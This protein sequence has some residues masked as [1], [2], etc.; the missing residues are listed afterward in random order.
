MDR[1]LIETPHTDDECLGLLDQII[2]AGYLHHFDW[3]C[4][5]GDHTG[6]AVI[7]AESQA[8]AA[9][10]VPAM[11]RAKARVVRLNKF[12]EEDVQKLHVAG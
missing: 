12:T 8:Q 11:V 3:G 9:L 10:A 6:W 7:E 4:Q 5:D 2:A 1:Y